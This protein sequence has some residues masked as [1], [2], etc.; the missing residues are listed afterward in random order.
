MGL[1]NRKKS[2]MKVDIKMF[3]EAMIRN[4]L[5]LFLEKPI[6]YKCQFKNVQI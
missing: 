4:V 5:C 3:S 6:D 2:I 1:F